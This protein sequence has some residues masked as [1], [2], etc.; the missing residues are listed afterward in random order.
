MRHVIELP[1]EIEQ[2]LEKRACETGQHVAHLIEAAVAAFIGNGDRAS[3]RLMPDPPLEAAEIPPP[4]DLPRSRS[5]LITIEK[6]SRRMP[7]LM[8]ES[9]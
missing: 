2:A 6:T 7:E 4:C 5:R 8:T 3:S 1:A 9:A